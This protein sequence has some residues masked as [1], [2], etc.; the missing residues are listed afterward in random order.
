[1]NQGDKITLHSKTGS[2]R[3]MRGDE[4]TADGR[5]YYWMHDQDDPQGEPI[6]YLAD[7]IDKLAVAAKGTVRRNKYTN[8]SYQMTRAKAG[9]F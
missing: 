5:R 4:Y 3:L 7:N 8:R 1:M 6:P 9:G 2:R